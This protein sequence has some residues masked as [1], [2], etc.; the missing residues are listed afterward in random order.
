MIIASTHLGIDGE[1]VIKLIREH[2]DS[3][4]VSVNHRD[5]EESATRYTKFHEAWFQYH[6]ALDVEVKKCEAFIEA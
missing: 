1:I 3:H 2:H 6:K 4:I 5:V